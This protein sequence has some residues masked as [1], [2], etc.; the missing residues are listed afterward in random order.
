MNYRGIAWQNPTYHQRDF[1]F[2]RLKTRAVKTRHRNPSEYHE[3]NFSILSDFDR[4]TISFS[5]RITFFFY[6]NI[7]FAFEL[8]THTRIYVPHTWHRWAE[9]ERDQKISVEREGESEKEVRRRW[10]AGSRIRKVEGKRWTDKG[11]T[12]KRNELLPCRRRSVTDSSVFISFWHDSL[13]SFLPLLS[14]LILANS[15]YLRLAFRVLPC[16]RAGSGKG[17]KKRPAKGSCSCFRRREREWNLFSRTRLIL[18][19]D[20]LLMNILRQAPL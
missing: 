6:G 12:V 11:W 1:S 19:V 16:N 3:R 5:R 13:V 8:R 14:P 15:L 20:R 4:E 17:A 7:S 10:R 9:R 2:E 18:S